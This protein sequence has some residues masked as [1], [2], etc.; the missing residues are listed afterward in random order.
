MSPTPRAYGCMAT[1]PRHSFAGRRMRR[2]Y[3]DR[4]PKE[5]TRVLSLGGVL[6]VLFCRHGQKSTSYHQTDKPK[7]EAQP[8]LP[9]VGNIRL[10]HNNADNY[11]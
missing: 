6:L 4:L 5:R 11:A 10:I 7:F 2:M 9:V 3:G 8:T 1:E